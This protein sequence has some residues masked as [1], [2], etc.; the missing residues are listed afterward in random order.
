VLEDCNV[1]HTCTVFCTCNTHQFQN[2]GSIF[3]NR[4]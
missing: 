4:L 2:L 1:R 3:R